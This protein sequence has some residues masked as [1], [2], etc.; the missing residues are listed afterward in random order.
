MIKQV[1]VSEF[2]RAAEVIR[3]SFATVAKEFNLTE[4]NCPTHTSFST[5]VETLRQNIEWGWLMYGF[6]DEGQLIGYIAI[7]KE[8]G[9][10]RNVYELHNVAV[11]P[12]YRHKGYG[13][14]LLDFCKEKVKKLGGNKITI[15]IIDEHTVLKNWYAANGFVHTG[16]KKFEQFPFTVGYMEYIDKEVNIL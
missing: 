4:Q 5:T 13:R 2:P 12:E 10:G 3:T 14:K 7:S 1:D 11:L 8:Y 16:T 6:Y 9:T 15:G